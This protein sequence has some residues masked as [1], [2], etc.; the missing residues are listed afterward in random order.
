MPKYIPDTKLDEWELR[1]RYQTVF[2]K[3]GASIAAPTA[4]LHFTKEVFRSLSE[5]HIEKR[6]VTLHV[7]QG[8]FAPV[9]DKNFEEKKIHR[10]YF[11]IQKKMVEAIQKAKKEARA[12]GAAGTSTVR[13][14]E[15]SAK[16]LF[17]TPD[18]IDSSTDIFIFPP[19]QFQIVDYLITN[20]HLPKSSLMLVVDAFLK[21]KKAKQSLS[22]LYKIAIQEKFRFYSFGDSMLI[23]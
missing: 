18:E 3:A 13:A 10:E 8:T 19:Y 4:S 21:D 5:R 15:S 2:A 12:C 16:T 9:T 22:D 14:L 11:E 17:E 23:L 6:Y 20:F 7:G 1:S